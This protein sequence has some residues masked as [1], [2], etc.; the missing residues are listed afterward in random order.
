MKYSLLT[1]KNEEPDS[2]SPDTLRTSSGR[3]D[4]RATAQQMHVVT[5]RDAAT[6][7]VFA[8]NAYN[9]EFPG[10][11]FF[12]CSELCLDDRRPGIVS[13]KKWLAGS[14][15]RAARQAASVFGAGL[16]PCAALHIA[17]TLQPGEAEGG[18]SLGPSNGSARAPTRL[19][20][21]RGGFDNAVSRHSI[22]S[23]GMEPE[24]RGHPVQTPDDSFDVLMNHWLLYQTVSCRLW[25][26]S[27]YYQPSGAFDF[28]AISCRT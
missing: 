20:A 23:V 27:G 26:R 14:A 25:A 6:G 3:W 9:T 24:P 4:R 16:D 5:G 8:T 7:A 11:A 10:V 1:L 21:L 28:P 15:R 2:A 19:I 12:G 13:R 22:E 18:I 17:V